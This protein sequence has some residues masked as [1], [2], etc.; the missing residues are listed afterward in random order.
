MDTSSLDAAYRD[1]IHNA[2]AIIDSTRLSEDARSLIDW[3]TAHLALSDRILAAAARDVLTGV[4]AV[5]DNREAMNAKAIDA[6][7]GATSPQERVDLVRRN[8]AD[9]IATVQAVPEH[10]ADTPVR[11]SIVDR[12]G[13]PVP[14]QQL[15]WSELIHLRATQ[16]VPGHAARIA[17]QSSH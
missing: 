12:D 8:A 1:L 4:P 3:T 9:L 10:A 15:P 16:H 5:V 14:D 11:L 17:Q 13:H 7:I 2:E 6:L